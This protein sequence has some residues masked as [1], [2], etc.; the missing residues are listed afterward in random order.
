MTCCLFT[1]NRALGTGGAPY[2]S[3]T[4][5]TILGCTF[6][7]NR[8]EPAA[9]LNWMLRTGDASYRLGLDNCIIWDG[10]KS[11]A[12]SL[13]MRTRTE[14]V[15]GEDPNLTIR[16]SD[17]QSGWP[18][19][20]NTDADPCFAGPGYCVDGDY[21]LKSQAGRWDL[22]SE[23]LGHRRGHQSLYRRRRSEHCGGRRAG[24]QWRAVQCGRLRRHG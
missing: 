15:E 4:E 20:G 12:S 16:Y 2:T 23:N 10:E 22:A 13:Y 19:E 1:V 14:V 5:F 6:A 18:G 11:I 9:T 8:A 21:H 17:V 7:D 3:Y 24:A